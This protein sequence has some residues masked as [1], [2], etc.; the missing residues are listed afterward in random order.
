[1]QP[2]A[3]QDVYKLSHKKRIDL[4]CITNNTIKTLFDET[5]GEVNPP[6]L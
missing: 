4:T 5:A 2:T 6:F 3:N 1:V